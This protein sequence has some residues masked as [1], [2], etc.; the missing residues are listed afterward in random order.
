MGKEIEAKL[1]QKQKKKKKNEVWFYMDLDV[2]IKL[3]ELI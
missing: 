1:F 2:L 3:S